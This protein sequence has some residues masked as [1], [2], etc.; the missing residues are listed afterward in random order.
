MIGFAKGLGMVGLWWVVAM[1]MEGPRLFFVG[2]AAAAVVYFGQ[3][4]KHA[5]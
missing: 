4:G 3:R 2:L 5:A 1:G